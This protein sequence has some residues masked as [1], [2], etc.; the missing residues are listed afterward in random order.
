M[1][2]VSH[3]FVSYVH[4]VG[5]IVSDLDR[6][7]KFYTDI[8]GFEVL[9]KVDLVAGE[10]VSTAV[11]LPD[12]QLSVVH[13][14]AGD[15]PTRVELL[16]YLAPKSTPLPHRPRSNDIGVRHAA[17]HVRDIYGYYEKLKKSG[18]RFMSDVQVSSTGEKFCYFFDPDDAI[19]E[20]IQPPEGK[21][22]SL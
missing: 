1:S 10:D 3:E 16:H 20:L 6:S 8:L 2:E 17:F 21:L 13:L 11:R 12:A 18:V 14:K 4:H 9:E 15:G 7:L 22:R 5:I 19:L